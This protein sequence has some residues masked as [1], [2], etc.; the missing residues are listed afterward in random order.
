M[1][2]GELINFFKYIILKFNSFLTKIYFIRNK[3]LYFTTIIFCCFT[4]IFIF[5]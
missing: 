4:E 2:L 1:K 5:N 3:F